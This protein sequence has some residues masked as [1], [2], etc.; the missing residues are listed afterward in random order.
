[1]SRKSLPTEAIEAIERAGFTA[2][3]RNRLD[4]WCVYTD[5]KRIGYMQ[6]AEFVGY[7]ISTVHKPNILTGTGWQMIRE[8]FDLTPEN[9]AFGLMDYPSGATDKE[10]ESVRKYSGIEEYRESMRFNRPYKP[11][12]AKEDRAARDHA[13]NDLALFIINTREIYTRQTLPALRGGKKLHPGGEPMRKILQ[14][15]LTAWRAEFGD[16]DQAQMFRR[17]DVREEAA[18]QIAEHYTDHEDA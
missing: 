18:A 8:T 2:Y 11:V 14:A 6:R 10:R 13:A 7:S 12:S 17:E 4:S 15:G 16:D 5:G 3:M 9:L 1:M